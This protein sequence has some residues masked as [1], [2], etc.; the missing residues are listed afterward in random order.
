MITLETKDGGRAV[1]EFGTWE[2]SGTISDDDR[3]A[4]GIATTQSLERGQ[5]GEPE[6]RLL[7]ELIS[8]GFEATRTAAPTENNLIF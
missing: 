7:H 5:L 2:F 4:I 1:Y 6:G 8:L 3:Q